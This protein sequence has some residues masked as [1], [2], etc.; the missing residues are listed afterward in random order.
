[1]THEPYLDGADTRT[2]IQ[3]ARPPL[4]HSAAIVEQ[5]ALAVR[6]REMKPEQISAD[7]AERGYHNAI[8]GYREVARA[9]LRDIDKALTVEE[10][11]NRG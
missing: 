3:A 7:E 4:A 6:A 9:I 11:T 1:M 2:V 8:N 10:G 5:L